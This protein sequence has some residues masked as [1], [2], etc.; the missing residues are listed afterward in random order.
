[1]VLK[2]EAADLPAPIVVSTQAASSIFPEIGG[3]VR[4]GGALEGLQLSKLGGFLRRIVHKRRRRPELASGGQHPGF[5]VAICGRIGFVPFH[6]PGPVGPLPVHLV[7]EPSPLPRSI[8]RAA[9]RRPSSSPALMS[10]GY[11]TPASTRD[12][13]ASSAFAAKSEARSGNM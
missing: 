5:H 12:R 13:P 11:W 10:L 3:G 8:T 2:D 7:S 9:T 6:F 4:F 1:P